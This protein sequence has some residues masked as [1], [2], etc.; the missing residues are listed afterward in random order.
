MI[1]PSSQKA[2]A[3]LAEMIVTKCQS[4]RGHRESA[5]RIYGQWIERG[6]ASDDGAGGLALANMLYSHNDRL[7]AYLFSPVQLAFLMAF[8]ER[9]KREWYERGVVAA[10]AVTNEWVADDIDILF[11]AAVKVSVDYGGCP[12]KQLVG[13]RP[14]ENG[15]PQFDF[16]GARIVMPQMFGVMN[17]TI[18]DLD[19]Q[20]AFVETT[21]MN[22][23]EVWRRVRH[24]PDADKLMKR[25]KSNSEKQA[26]VSPPTSFMHQVLSTAVLDL[27]PAAAGQPRPGGWVQTGGGNNYPNA[28]PQ[29]D[30]DLYPVEEIWVKDDDTGDWTTMMWMRPDILISPYGRPM[31]M[32]VPG[33]HPYSLVQA[34]FEPGYFWGRSEVADLMQ[35]Q[36]WLTTHLS[37]I[38]KIMGQQFDKFIGYSGQDVILGEQ[39]AMNKA[40]GYVS[41]GQGGSATDLTPKMPEQAIPL[42]R[43]ILFLMERVSG[44]P[45][46]MSGEGT[47]GVR[48]GVHA[49]TL[50][51]TGSPRLRDRSLAIERQ[52]AKAGGLTFAILAAKGTSV[53]WTDPHKN[54]LDFTLEQVAQLN[55]RIEV[56]SHSSSPIYHDD[57]VQLV[58][59]LA[60]AGILD[61]V[62]AVEMLNLPNKDLII[63]RIKEREK[64]QQAMMQKLEQ[65][66]PEAFA[67]VIG[68][69]SAGHRRAA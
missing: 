9:L 52:C 56:D 2:R 10:R 46:V 62:S 33:H 69:R 25:I 6:W 11:G 23:W 12:L 18:N 63:E 41:L 42:I 30:I 31:N 37:D 22:E 36:A 61:P 40:Q 58:A 32:C 38:N 60:K 21:L 1:I 17:E 14:G 59:F 45:P 8:E 44:F 3:D 43:E 24:L 50:V 7:A 55:P 49:D 13:Q 34:N 54:N 15:K 27:S 47:P 26:G 48:A 57:H 64:T 29:V 35:L 16:H 39:Y 4:S 28:G 20:E 66:D 51:K 5:Y 68:G 53:Y 67:K 19:K 65:E